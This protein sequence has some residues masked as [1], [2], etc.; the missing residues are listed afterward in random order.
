[1]LC[2]TRGILITVEGIDGSG[3]TTLVRNLGQALAALSLPVVLTREPGATPLGTVIRQLVQEKQVSICPKAEYL[4]FASNRAQHFNDIIIPNLTN[5]NIVISDRMADS[6]LV[7][8]GFGRGLD[9]NMLTTINQWSMNNITPDITLYVKI[10][11]EESRARLRARNEALTSFEKEKESFTAQLL[12][13]FET[14]FAHRDNV[15][16]IDGTQTPEQLTA[17]ARDYVVHWI[18][19]NG[20]AQ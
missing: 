10:D 12:N 8:Q 18:N 19:A 1:M 16:T 3:K 11:L 7:Y 15:H 14:I 5:K 6:S 13:G 9:L 20:L 4:L 2:L 17:T